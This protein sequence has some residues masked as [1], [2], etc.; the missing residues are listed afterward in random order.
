MV[1]SDVES[2]SREF[3]AFLGEFAGRFP[4]VES[5]RQ[6][7][8][9]LRGLLSE[10]ERKNGWTLAEMAGERGPERLQR[11]LNFYAW[12]T[13]GVRDDVRRMVV[14]CI[15]DP[16][17]GVLI[18]D[19]TG[20]LKKGVRSAGVA[21]QYS[22][23]AGRIEN[24]QIGVF[25]AYAGPKGRALIDRELY[26]PKAWIDDRE[27]CRLAGIGDEVGFATKP[28]LGIAML[29]RAVEARV[30]FGWVTADEAYG[31]VGRLRL[32]LEQRHIAHVLCVPRT[33]M[34]ISMGLTQER[35]HHL[36]G[37][38][39]P[40]DWHRLSCGDGARGRREYHWAAISIRPLREP[41]V[42]HWLLARRSIAKPEEIAY[43]ICFANEN[44][45]LAELVGVAGSRWAVE[46]C[47]Q[48]A[49]NETGLD[50]YQVRGYQ[51]WYRH[52]TLSMTAAA[53][54]LRL[55]RGQQKGD[56]ADTDRY[57]STL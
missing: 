18:L 54:L 28:D 41:G 19:D 6:A 56:L 2:W 45:S 48:A 12:D 1:I 20:F 32:W 53:F 57:H 3:S 43:Y 51:A 36:A 37:Q 13:D 10:L 35:A 27:R 50:H 7:A 46:E 30:P 15:A 39:Q 42:G 26:L 17:D 47:F 22:G 23:T 52:V 21:R 14:D 16:R 49:K 33:Q 38:L 34:V 44:T 9:Y 40:G 31:Q 25:C 4:R 24:C 5:R 29:A 55:Q 11:L 8:S